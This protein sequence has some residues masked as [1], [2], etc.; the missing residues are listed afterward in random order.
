LNVVGVYDEK[1]GKSVGEVKAGEN[2]DA[3]MYDPASKQ[4][5]A[6]NNHGGTA[7]VIDPKTLKVTATIEIGGKLEFGRADGKGN[8]WVN[9]EDKSEIIHLDSKKRTVLAR[10]KLAPCEEPTGLAFDEKHRRLFAGCNNNMMVVV[11]ADSGKVITTAPIGPGVD[12]TAF[13]PA[14][15]DIFNSC[16]GGDGSLVV[17]HQDG[18]DKYSVAQT[19]ATQKRAKTLAVDAKTHRVFVTAGSFGPAPAATPENPKP[20]PPMVPGSFGVMIFQK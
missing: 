6:F 4:I 17:V 7:T 19:I 3:V 1:T 14:T 20:R 11:D 13:D 2:P 15:G 9:A 16:G 18:A 5:F 10:W 12:A 8:V